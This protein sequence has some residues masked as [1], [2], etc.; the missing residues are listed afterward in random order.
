[1]LRL[2]VLGGLTLLDSDGHQV[3]PQRLRLAL[4]ALLATAGDRGMSRD[5][6]IAYLWPES[7]PENA[8]HALEQLLYSL[9]RQVPLGLIMGTDPLRLDPDKVSSDLAEF[10]SRTFTGDLMIMT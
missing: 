4:L 7:A 8:R 10:G 6:L 9:R 3:V 5:K 1:M 2:G